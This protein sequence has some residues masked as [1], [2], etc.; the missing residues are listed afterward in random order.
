MTYVTDED[1]LQSELVRRAGS[2]GKLGRLV[3]AA[4]KD[5]LAAGGRLMHASLVCCSYKSRPVVGFVRLSRPKILHP[6][7]MHLATQVIFDAQTLGLVCRLRM[8][9]RVPHGEIGWARGMPT[10]NAVVAETYVCMLI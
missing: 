9:Q 10:R 8:P 6:A 5:V 7:C 1:T 4:R 3:C 2:N